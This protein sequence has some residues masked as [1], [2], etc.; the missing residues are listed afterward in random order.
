MQDR[1]PE[2]L[3]PH[4]LRDYYYLKQEHLGNANPFI[5]HKTA[6]ER[7]ISVYYIYHCIP[8][9]ENHE[10]PDD[11][12]GINFISTIAEKLIHFPTTTRKARK[13]FEN[14]DDLAEQLKSKK[15]DIVSLVMKTF[16][17]EELRGYGY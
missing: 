11:P 9:P 7:L 4:Y 15:S 13:V 10:N 16:T 6:A 14:V 3:I 12:T 5:D 2:C 1:E 17:L 8:T